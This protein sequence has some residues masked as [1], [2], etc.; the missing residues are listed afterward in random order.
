MAKEVKK[1]PIK[2]ERKTALKPSR[3]V[4][5]VKKKP[6]SVPSKKALAQPIAQGNTSKKVK[7]V[8]NNISRTERKKLKIIDKTSKKAVP[9]L[10]P[11]QKTQLAIASPYRFPLVPSTKALAIVT[12]TFGLLFVLVGTM[13][14]LV[15]LPSA[16]PGGV[17]MMSNSL[18]AT[19]DGTYTTSPNILNTTSSA[20]FS[21]DPIASVNTT[22]QKPK[23]H[24][25]VSSPDGNL[26]GNVP[27]SITVPNAT[28]VKVM[29]GNKTS[30]Q[31]HPLGVAKNVDPSTWSATID[32]EKY[33]PGEYRVK[34]LIENRN[35]VYDYVDTSSYFIKEPEPVVTPTKTE[36]VTITDDS[37]DSTV[38][39]QEA[40]D[41]LSPATETVSPSEPEILFSASQSD[42]LS[43]L[44]TFTVNVAGA[45][46]VKVGIKNNAN[47]ALYSTG[48]L[49][50]KDGGVWSIDWDSKRVPDG[51]YTFTPRVS[52]VG[53]QYS[54]DH[55]IFG[56]K[57]GISNVLS[58]PIASSTVP[59]VTTGIVPAEPTVVTTL[60]KTNPLFGFVDVTFTSN[61]VIET[62]EVYVTP[63][64][65]L[66]PRFL[67]LAYKESD[68]KWKFVWGTE[69]SP[70]GN[71][72][73]YTR[74]KTAHGFTDTGK[75][76]VSIM[77]E[78]IA[79]FTNEQEQKIDVMQRAESELISVVEEE[80][81]D[82]VE[83]ATSEEKEKITYVE[84]VSTFVE[85]IETDEET[86]VDVSSI[87]KDFREK[88]NQKLHELARAKR[89]G[90]EESIQKIKADIENLRS[91]AL[92][93]L[94]KNM[95]KK[96]LISEI[97]QYL[98]QVSYE[99]S[100][101]VIKNETLLKERVG[102]AIT[103]DSDRDEI[104]DYDE[105]N[106]Y[107]TNPFS[108]DS[109][110]DGHNDNVEIL[111]GFDAL[112]S[113]AESPVVY[114]S[115]KETGIVRE[116]ILLV[117]TVHTV[118][119]G[120]DTEAPKALISGKA[121]PNSFVTLYIYSTPVVVT[122]KT[123]DEGNWNYILDKTLEDGDHEVYV[124][125]TDNEGKIVAKSNPISFVKTAEAYTS[126][127]S[128][129]Q[130]QPAAAPSLIR[131]DAQ[132]LLTLASLIVLALGLVLVFVGL[133]IRKEDEQLYRPA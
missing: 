96:E 111:Q 14:S 97:S 86:K 13:L 94:P 11:E 64:N 51:E 109:D 114:E 45:D 41:V 19:F 100:D 24:V 43:G 74:V 99:L 31:I 87:L 42:P 71:Y 104:S 32:A 6:I 113:E 3:A 78:S 9:Q 69:N 72:Y 108:A 29:L 91:E 16:I 49:T 124:G 63:Q 75:K 92:S 37:D 76:Y 68:T 34:L 103:N 5:S 106:L 119:K 10:A 101:V 17:S 70:N 95:E 2:S 115:P 46:S 60:S 131:I 20:T 54:G 56:V 82:R 36:E 129:V 48:F 126:D 127:V 33:P 27:V 57:N 125:I 4:N 65:S 130:T 39:T 62:L 35:T 117:E 84:P 132:G 53:V 79:D 90:D 21:T 120:T 38:S 23:P 44:V 50:K 112:S 59:K 18:S 83:P 67:G 102:S 123:D 52:I 1:L 110:G 30:N 40:T 133:H 61:Q 22:D 89:A 118:E 26:E 12:Y 25:S 121:L 88:L 116:D 73:L 47:G 85:A 105:I 98:T 58:T 15:H 55:T 28:G 128:D 93:A 66:M 8:L 77:N 122:V 107:K 81:S 7:L 80:D